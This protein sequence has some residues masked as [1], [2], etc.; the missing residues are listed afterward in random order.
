M[1][2]S[3]SV[4]DRKETNKFLLNLYTAVIGSTRKCDTIRNVEQLKD[5]VNR[6]HYFTEIYCL[7]YYSTQLINSHVAAYYFYSL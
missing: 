7:Q 5:G 4:I 2:L 6:H 3:N 1:L